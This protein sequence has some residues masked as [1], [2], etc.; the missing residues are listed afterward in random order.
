MFSPGNTEPES[1]ATLASLQKKSPMSNNRSDIRNWIERY[2]DGLLPQEEKNKLPAFL[3]DP[4]FRREFYR[5]QAL[6]EVIREK[7][8]KAYE[9]LLEGAD[10]G[11]DD[12]ALLRQFGEWS[13]EKEATDAGVIPIGRGAPHFRRRIFRWAAAAVLIL[14]IAGA[15]TF[16]WIKERSSPSAII[17]QQVYDSSFFLESTLN[18]QSDREFYEGVLLLEEKQYG[19]ALSKFLAVPE[20]HSK[21]AEA[22]LYAADCSLHL[23]KYDD[24][25]VLYDR[26]LSDLPPL[27][28]QK[29]PAL[30]FNRLLAR[31]GHGSIDREPLLIEGKK[32]LEEYDPVKADALEK[33]LTG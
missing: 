11:A 21:Y 27:L 10:T 28:E 20:D 4:A 15:G 30:E 33:Q 24:A 12:Q 19:R 25:I 5:Q 17:A 18:A 8:S 7:E 6:W 22:R 1:F 26:L 13:K 9:K 16:L 3:K 14:A 31:F 32:I 23:G 2:S 29:R